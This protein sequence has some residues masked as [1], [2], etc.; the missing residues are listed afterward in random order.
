MTERYEAT[1]QT[2][3]GAATHGSLAVYDNGIG[4]ESRDEKVQLSFEEILGV[5]IGRLPHDKLSGRPTLMIH[6]HD[7]I[8][9]VA[10]PGAGLLIELCDRLAKA[11]TANSDSCGTVAVVVPLREGS[12][13]RAQQL[14]A[15]GPPFDLAA[16]G[17][18]IHQ[19]FLTEQEAVFVFTGH[20]VRRS[21]EQALRNPK[22][23]RAGLSWRSCVAGRPRVSQTQYIWAAAPV[24]S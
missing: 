10:V 21:I 22:V 24:A 14:V 5:E 18:E 9:R 11:L 15:E 17:I 2:S 1:W 12:G 4:L 7:G 13:L 20:D 3:E 16:Y 8:R 6:H 23:W 19:V